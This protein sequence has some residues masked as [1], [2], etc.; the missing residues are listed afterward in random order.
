MSL[1]QLHSDNAELRAQLAN[2]ASSLDR[3]A[4]DRSALLTQVEALNSQLVSSAQAVEGVEADNRRLMQELYSERSQNA[5]LT[6]RVAALLKRAAA[7]SDASKVMS[8]RLAAVERERDAMRSVATME[9]QKA[10]ELG[11]VVEIS[12]AQAATASAQLNRYICTY[13]HICI[14]T[15]IHIYA[16][17]HVG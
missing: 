4:F 11:A 16:Y 10:S 2:K 7:A 9:R 12:R 15:Y 1:Q 8:A 3:E 13:V 14:Y 17:I 6:E 5:M